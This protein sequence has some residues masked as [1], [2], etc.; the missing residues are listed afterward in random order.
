[1]KQTTSNQFD[2]VA[3]KTCKDIPTGL[4]PYDTPKGENVGKNGNMPKENY[5]H[6][7]DKV[8]SENGVPKSSY[9]YVGDKVGKSNS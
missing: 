2:T 4:Y 1:M 7:G 8:G 5:S 6:K 3:F 9:N